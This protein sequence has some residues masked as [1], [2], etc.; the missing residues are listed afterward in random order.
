MEEYRS[1]NAPRDRRRILLLPISYGSSSLTLLH[2]LHSQLARQ[3]SGG[4]GRIPYE[5]YILNVERSVREK[6]EISRLDI[7][8]KVFPKH[9]YSEIALETVFEYDGEIDSFLNRHGYTVADSEKKSNRERLDRLMSSLSTASARADIEWTLLHRLIVSFAKSAGCDSI[10]WG[11]CDSRLA[12]KALASVAKGRGFS[13]PWEVGDGMSP[14]GIRFNF[15]MR[16]IFQSEV[17]QYASIAFENIPNI[18]EEKASKADQSSKHMSIDDLMSQYVEGQ[19]EKYSG[20]IANIVKTIGKLN[21]GPDVG[22][23]CQLCGLP[24]DPEDTEQSLNA[25]CFGCLRSVADVRS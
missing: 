4:K 14:L 2:V 6:P 17:N 23:R 21:P 1:K 25:L 19:S 13:L 24:T 5:L 7:I 8:K 20:V 18:M 11:D 12:A 16:D 15:P 22:I 9:S 10:L 3:L